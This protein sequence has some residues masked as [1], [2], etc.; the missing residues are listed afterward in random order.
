MNDLKAGGHHHLMAPNAAPQLLSSSKGAQSLAAVPRASRLRA[1]HSDPPAGPAMFSSEACIRLASDE[2]NHH[3]DATHA[4]EMAHERLGLQETCNDAVLRLRR[5]TP[6]WDKWW[7]IRISTTIEVQTFF[8]PI[9]RKTYMNVHITTHV[10]HIH[11]RVRLLTAHLERRGLGI[12][13]QFYKISTESVFACARRCK[14]KRY[15][16]T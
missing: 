8:F 16:P 4:A 3:Q 12:N 15:I 6:P 11:A 2:R 13:L 9:T 5:F 14:F 7:R 10:H 1:S